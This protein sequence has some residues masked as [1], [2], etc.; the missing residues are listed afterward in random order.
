M[1][2]TWQALL[3]YAGALALLVATPGPVVAALIARSATG[4]VRA[5][6]PLAAGVGVGDVVWP[7]L[8]LLGI[9]AVVGVWGGVLVALRYV[10]AAIL[11]WMGIDL[12]RTAEA[13]AVRAGGLG[14]ESGWAAFT[15]GLMVIAG[16]PK[17]ILFYLG[18]LPG[19]FDLETLT[20]ADVAVICAVSVL[21]PF[22]GNLT[23]AALFARARR[24]LANPTA[25]KR[26]HVVAGVALVCVGIAIA[27]G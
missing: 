5:A 27:L 10:G 1:T 15:A 22:L 23:W 18:V 3:P 21:V 6:V 17:A 12:V 19:F 2:L 25:M 11:V 24:W 8:A 26:T 13:K 4:G 7:L 14:R 16:N 20:A 9:G